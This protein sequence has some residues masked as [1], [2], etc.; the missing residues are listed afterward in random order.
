M[1]ALVVPFIRY[2]VQ[3]ESRKT[4]LG[5]MLIVESCSAC[6]NDTDVVLIING[7]VRGENMFVHDTVG[8]K[9]DRAEDGSGG[10]GVGHGAAGVEY[11][12]EVLGIDP[13]RVETNG[14]VPDGLGRYPVGAA[15]MRV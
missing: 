3:L 15:T 1:C 9:H 14:T 10:S 12:M 11:K 13:S 4:V 7:V 8:N 2:S 6:M 5:V